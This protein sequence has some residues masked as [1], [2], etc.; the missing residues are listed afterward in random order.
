MLIFEAVMNAIDRMNNDYNY[1]RQSMWKKFIS[2]V[3]TAKKKKKE[4]KMVW[5]SL[6]NLIKFVDRFATLCSFLNIRKRCK[7]CLVV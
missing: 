2:T 1:R 6:M 3:V 4:S 5:L 7:C